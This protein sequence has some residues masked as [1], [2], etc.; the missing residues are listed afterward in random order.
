[1]PVT[2][3]RALE[4]VDEAASSD[5]SAQGRAYEALVAATS[6]TVPW[7]YDIWPHI[8]EGLGSRDNRLRSICAQILANLAAHS[9]PED[10]ILGDLDRLAAVMAD[11]R[12]VTARHTTQTL[13]KVGLGGEKQRTATVAALSR[14]FRACADEKNA[15]PIRTDIITALA[16]LDLACPDAGIEQSAR[17]LI[18]EE[19]DDTSRRKQASAWKK[20]RARAT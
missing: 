9:D 10:R 18:A 2:Q 7:A 4:L 3:Q 8:V 14:R 19:P 15:G 20:A 17:D 12:F 11:E 13:W 5:R 16:E 1:M 6:S